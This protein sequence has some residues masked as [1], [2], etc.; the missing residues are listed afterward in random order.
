ML[1]KVIGS[2]AGGGFPQWNCNYRLSR[3]ARA[4]LPG[5]RTRT[6]S[7]LAA[8]ADG[9]R[10]VLFNAS[11]DIRQQIE[12]NPNLQPPAGGGLRATPISAVVLTNADV[13]HVAGLLSLRERQ[14]FALYASRR[15][16]DVLAANPI[17]NVLDPEIVPRRE[18]PP[19]AVIQIRDAVGASTGLHVESFPVPG[20]VALYLEDSSGPG[21]DHLSDAG[22]TVGVR[23]TAEGAGA[24]T[25]YV[26]GCARVDPDL[27]SRFHDA[28]CLFFDGTFF[29]DDEMIKAGVG[30]KTGLRMAHVS[31]SGDN[32]SIAALSGVAIRR[33][34]FVHIN[35]TNPVLDEN[36]REYAEVTR[37][38]WEIAYDGLEISE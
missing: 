26:P 9:R 12:A 21:A 17:F 15:V 16:L 27:K 18:L 4:G 29:A 33:R 35:N 6:Q 7:S 22:D 36:S 10:W 24:S 1:L 37:Q 34:V 3:S 2:A 28:A 31:M 38:N 32:G 30:T 11:P 14:P 23:I 20:K 8:S 25:F 5:I 13:D 19:G